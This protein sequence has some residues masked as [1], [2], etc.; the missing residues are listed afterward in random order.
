MEKAS[1][2]PL[3]SVLVIT[4]NQEEYIVQAIESILSQRCDFEYELVIGE[5]CSTDSTKEK[6][7]ALQAKYPSKIRVISNE[8]NKGLLRNFYETLFE[9]RG[10]Y[11]AECAGDDFWTDPFKL[12]KQV[13]VLEADSEVV[14]V[15]T[16]WRELRVDSGIVKPDMHSRKPYFK[17]NR[18]GREY[19]QALINQ[20]KGPFVYT[21][22]A[23]YRKSIVEKIYHRYPTFFTDERYPCEDYQL[24]FFLLQEGFFYYLD[25][26][27]VTYRRLGE[28]ISASNNPAKSFDFHYRNLLLRIDIIQE[29]NLNLHDASEFLQYQSYSLSRLAFKAKRKDLAQMAQDKFAAIGFEVTSAD[30]LYNFITQH[31]ML[32]QT[33]HPLYQIGRRIKGLL[34]KTTS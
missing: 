14:L 4:Y 26:E 12:Q 9:C 28:S 31:S 22:S 8:Y 5:D 27:T 24:V 23:C 6:C 30:R 34:R 21:C 10:K 1:A 15:H 2:L 3:V 25:E 29:L 20:M 7:L 19:T 13:E 32:L 33:A 11:I 16:N 17:G 18:I